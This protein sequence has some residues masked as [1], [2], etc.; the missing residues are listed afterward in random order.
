MGFGLTG[1][2]GGAWVD[3]WL[4]HGMGDV[5]GVGKMHSCTTWIGEVGYLASGP[6]FFSHNAVPKG[7]FPRCYYEG[8]YKC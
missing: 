1:K 2:P 7:F 3:A 8:G 4:V 6:L 5:L